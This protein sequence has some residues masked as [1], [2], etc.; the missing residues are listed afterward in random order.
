MITVIQ[1]GYCGD[2]KKSLIRKLKG[3]VFSGFLVTCEPSKYMCSTGTP[4]LVEVD[5]VDV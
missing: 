3:C 2:K 1:F 4:E 5:E